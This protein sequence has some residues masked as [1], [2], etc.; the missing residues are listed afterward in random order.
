MLSGKMWIAFSFLSIIQYHIAY[1][2]VSNSSKDVLIKVNQSFNN[3]K[4]KTSQAENYSDTNKLAEV[5]INIEH[6]NYLLNGLI[7]NLVRSYGATEKSVLNQLLLEI[8]NYRDL[9]DISVKSASLDTVN[10]YLLF[11][12]NDLKLKYSNNFASSTN[13][14][15]DFVEVHVRVLNGQTNSEMSGYLAHV[16]PR[17]SINPVQV[18]N[19]NPT[20]HAIKNILPGDKLFWIEKDG[21][22]VA[23][24]QEGIEMT[25]TGT[26]EI[27][28]TIN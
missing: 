12:F 21:K 25:E 1:C 20:N 10:Y 27:V 22:I 4:L 14:S 17:C 28:F 19:F 8:G 7:G 26:A 13:I 24:R 9:F 2:Q 3:L 18:L 5:L 15:S 6:V 11:V 23:S 16:K